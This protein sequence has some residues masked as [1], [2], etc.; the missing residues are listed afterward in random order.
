MSEAR[1]LT[2]YE[3]FDLSLRQIDE[4]KVPERLKNAMRLGAIKAYEK[5]NRTG[6]LIAKEE[7]T[8]DD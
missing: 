7:G 3:K 2:D 5:T 4:M 6:E 8:T 1:D